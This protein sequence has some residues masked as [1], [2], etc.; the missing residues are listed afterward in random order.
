MESKSLMTFHFDGAK[1][2]ML[3]RY[4]MQLEVRNDN[5]RATHKIYLTGIF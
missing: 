2:N 3:Q 4:R 1:N 5:L